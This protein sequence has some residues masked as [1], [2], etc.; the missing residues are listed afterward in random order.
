M[1]GEKLVLSIV[2]CPYELLHSDDNTEIGRFLADAYAEVCNM[3]FYQRSSGAMFGE[4]SISCK[5]SHGERL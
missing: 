1:N 3:V 2:P 5:L 4:V